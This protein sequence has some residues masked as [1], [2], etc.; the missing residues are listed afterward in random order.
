M[1]IGLLYI[2]FPF[3]GILVKFFI[4][5]FLTSSKLR[6]DPSLVGRYIEWRYVVQSIGESPLFG[7]GVGSDYRL[8]NWF[9]GY[10]FTTSYTHNGY[11]GTL[12]KGGAVGFI[13]LFTAYIG[14]IRKGIILLRTRTLNSSERAFLRAG[15]TVLLLLTVAT[16]TFNI[17]AHR[18]VLL[19][20]GIIWGYILYIQR[21]TK[22]I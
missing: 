6:T 8:Y 16:N 11:L 14:F 17:F 12:L 9:E 5:Y 1:A 3:V 4:A 22:I 15:I 13:L 19:Y 21:T 7:H 2:I 18:D 20:I 10:S